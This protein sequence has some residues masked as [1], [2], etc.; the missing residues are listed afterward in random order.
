MRY[1][2]ILLTLVI[3]GIIAGLAWDL[4][5]GSLD[6]LSGFSTNKYDSFLSQINAKD[7]PFKVLAPSYTSSGFKFLRE[8]SAKI[9]Q[10]NVGFPQVNYMF[11]TTDGKNA[12]V[13]RQMDKARY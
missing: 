5:D 9:V 2:K 10:G 13:L 7:L 8:D 3:V 12:L 4:R 1:M 11:E 6:I